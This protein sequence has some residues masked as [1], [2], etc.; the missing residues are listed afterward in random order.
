MSTVE[1]KERA[2]GPVA[3]SAWKGRANHTITLPSGAVVVI[4]MPNLATLIRNDQLP[5]A[6]RAAAL[7]QAFDD[8]ETV[9][10]MGAEATTEEQR[11][12]LL[13]ERYKATKE[14]IDLQDGLIVEMMVDPPLTLE[15]VQLI[16]AEDRD[17]LIEIAQRDRFVDALGVRLGVAPLSAFREFRELHGCV[18]REPEGCEACKTLQQ[19]FSSSDVGEL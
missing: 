6:L 14:M 15:E 10:P 1:T 19:R 3:L 11:K 9:E 5:E 18:D 17:M 12:K 16:P 2:K 7:R 4:R 8:L 13:D